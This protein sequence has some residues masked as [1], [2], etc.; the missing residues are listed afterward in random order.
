[1]NDDE[2]S[3]FTISLSSRFHTLTIR[4]T[5]KLARALL[6]LGF[7]HNLKL[8]IM[9]SS[10]R[11]SAFEKVVS[12]HIDITKQNLVAPNKIILQMA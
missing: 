6:L 3:K 5:K 10:V 1:L 11:K 8:V 9:T 2:V 7:F 12:S 4:S